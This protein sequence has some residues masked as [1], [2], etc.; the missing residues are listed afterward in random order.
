MN[1]KHWYAS[2][3]LWVNLA[4]VLAGVGTYF[5]TG[6]TEPLLVAG[7]AFINFVLRLFTKK[8]IE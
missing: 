5:G 7:L 4:A 3:T 6:E 2:K 1:P 8:P